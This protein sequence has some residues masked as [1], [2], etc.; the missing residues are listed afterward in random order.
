MAR[1]V[2][3]NLGMLFRRELVMFGPREVL[4]T[5][6]EPVVKQFLN[7]HMNGPIGMSEEKDQAT[8][9]AEA[10]AAA[11]PAQG[12]LLEEVS[13]HPARRCSARP[14]VPER[15]A[16]GRRQQRVVEM[17]HTLPPTAQAAIRELLDKEHAQDDAVRAH[18]AAGHDPA[19]PA[20]TPTRSPDAHRGNG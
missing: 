20:T 13:R 16:V 8:M 1:T 19:L 17:L 7:G 11:T 18:W 6:E 14:G 3:D 4:L 2:P 5:S 9:A 10:A 15:K 12:P